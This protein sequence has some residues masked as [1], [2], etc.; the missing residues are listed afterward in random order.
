MDINE[1]KKLINEEVNKRK[2]IKEAVQAN[3]KEYLIMK[4]LLELSPQKLQQIINNLNQK[5]YRSNISGVSGII[6]AFKDVATL[7]NKLNAITLP[8]P[9]DEMIEDPEFKSLDYNKLLSSFYD[10]FMLDTEKYFHP[11]VS[12]LK[13][14]SETGIPSDN[15]QISKPPQNLTNPASPAA[16]AK[17]QAVDPQAKTI[18]PKTRR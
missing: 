9:A 12:F 18:P 5:G 15:K 11:V 4:V 10:E 8:K 6:N 13:H 2:A 17:V 1:L 7:G 14:A 3:P 16:K